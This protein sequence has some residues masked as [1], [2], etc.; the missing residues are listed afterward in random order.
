MLNPFGALLTIEAPDMARLAFWPVLAMV[1]IAAIVDLR[2][3]RIPNRLVLPLLAAAP[4]VAVASG[5]WSGVKESLAGAGLA[6][7]AALPLVL[8]KGM[9]MG[10][11]KLLAAVGAWIGPSQTV[12]ALVATGLAGGLIALAWA[13]AQRNRRA[14]FARSVDGIRALAVGFRHVEGWRSPAITLKQPRTGTLPYAPAIALG[15]MFSF[16]AR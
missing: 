1:A 5:G 7:A 13:L 4:A 16:F 11:L 6:I 12:I 3:R 9:G 2:S 8:L 10:D 14:A 15:T